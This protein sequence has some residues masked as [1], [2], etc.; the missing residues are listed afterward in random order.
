M[1]DIAIVILAA[2]KGVRMHSRQ[3]KVLHNVGGKPMICHAW[4]VA[5]PLATRPPVVVVP[6][7]DASIQALLGDQ[8]TYVVQPEPLGTGHALRMAAPLL[9]GRTD[10]TLVT[11]ADMP[12]LRSETLQ[13]LINVQATTGAAIALLYVEGEPQ[14]SFG[15][16]VRN[17]QGEV[18]EIVEVAEARQRPDPAAWLSIRTLNVG[19]YCFDAPWLWDTLPHLPLRQARTGQEYYLTDLVGLAVAQG[20]CVVGVPLHDA[21]EALGVGTRA[22]LVTVEKAFR[23]RAVERWLAAGVTILDPETTYIDQDVGIGQDTILRPQTYLQGQTVVGAAC[24]IGPNATLRQTRI[25][26]RCRVEQAVLENVT[27]PDDT[28]LAPFT[29]LVHP[30]DQG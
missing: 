18:M 15:R 16:V 14:S 11:Y 2:G 12:L 20:R 28:I 24:V 6:P 8:A 7:D 1:P 10:Q 25:G 26:D 27:L 21:D 4:A 9:T 17:V 30:P 19:V 22:E 29:H 5:G 13:E 23:R 3:P